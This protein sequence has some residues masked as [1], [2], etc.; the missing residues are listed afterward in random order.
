MR[1]H[2]ADIHVTAPVVMVSQRSRT[3]TGNIHH[4]VCSGEAPWAKVDGWK[5]SKAS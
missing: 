1:P 2:F 5:W 3:R 4:S